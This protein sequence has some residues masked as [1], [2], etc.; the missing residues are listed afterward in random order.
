M[1]ARDHWI[2]AIF[3]ALIVGTVITICFALHYRQQRI[4][5][6][7]GY[8]RGTLNGHV[9]AEWIA[10]ADSTSPHPNP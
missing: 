4:Y 10:P 2:G 9:G 5:V 6:E 7:H 1:N 8:T 3:L